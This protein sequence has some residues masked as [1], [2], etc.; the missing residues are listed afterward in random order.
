MTF[1]NTVMNLSGTFLRFVLVNLLDYLTWSRCVLSTTGNEKESTLL[2]SGSFQCS[3]SQQ[4]NVGF[5]VFN[6]Y[7]NFQ[8]RSLPLSVS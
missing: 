5:S 1:L 2:D 8:E 3:S 7:A 4:K 6:C